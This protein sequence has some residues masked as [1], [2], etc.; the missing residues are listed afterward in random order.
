MKIIKNQKFYKRLE[1][2]LITYN[3]DFYVERTLNQ[4]L[5]SPF[6]KCKFTVL[7]NCSKDKTPEICLKYKKLF[8]DFHII[9]HKKNIGGAINHLR[10]IEIATAEYTWIICDDDLYDFSYCDDI[11]E[12][13]EKSSH[14]ILSVGNGI[15]KFSRRGI[16]T[17]TQELVNNREMYYTIH[18]FIPATIFKTELFDSECIQKVSVMIK[19][20]FQHLYF[21]HTT[22]LRNCSVYI[23]KNEILLPDPARRIDVFNPFFKFTS[24]V[25]TS[26]MI[27]DKTIRKQFIYEY[28]LYKKS[29]FIAKMLYYIYFEKVLNQQGRFDFGKEGLRTKFFILCSAFS[30]F[31][32]FI[33]ILLIP[34]FLTPAFFYRIAG[35]V[36]LNIYYSGNIPADKIPT[37]K[38]DSWL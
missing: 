27:S 2:I 31:Q 1:I 12:V 20:I 7:D 15:Y 29:L 25:N 9:R 24:W 4:F 13:I 14:D 30:G 21:I 16:S 26:L 23:S 28:F 8:P 11:I 6:K 35:K 19:D 33:L 17:T 34:L 36:I 32:L 10:A 22:V 38:V 37:K 18:G 3:Q 5:K